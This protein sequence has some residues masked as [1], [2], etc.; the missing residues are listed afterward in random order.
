MKL[1]LLLVNLALVNI[2]AIPTAFAESKNINNEE[3]KPSITITNIPQI[4][5]IELPATSAKLLTQQP[6]TNQNQNCQP[7]SQNRNEDEK[8]QL[9]K[10]K[11]LAQNQEET[12]D[13]EIT[14]TGTKTPRSV[15]DSPG[16]ITVIDTDDID[17]R[18]IQNLDDLIRYEP[19][20]ST[21]GDPR[22]Y[23]FQDFNIRGIDGNRILLQVDGVRLPESFSFGSTRLGRNYV[24]IETLKRAEIIRGSAST[25]Y[26]SDAIGGVVTFITKDPEDYLQESGDDAYFSNKFAYDSS[27][28]GIA[29]TATVAGRSGDVEGLLV[30]TRRDGYEPQ[31]NSSRTPNPQVSSAN[32]WLAKLVFNLSDFQ[33]IKLTGE[34]IN[35]T[36]NTDVLTSRGINLGV[37]TDNLNA[38]DKTKRNRY[39]LSYEYDNPNNSLF[40]QVLRSQIYYQDAITTEESNELRRATAPIATGEVN[41][42]RYRNSS[43]QQNT[44]G[45][46]LQLESNFDTGSLIHKLVY[47]AEVSQTKTSRLRDGFQENI[48]SPGV[49]GLRTNVVGPDAFPVKDIADTENTKFGIYLQDE[50]T[51]GN[52]TLIPGIR[53]D[54]YSLNPQPDQ[55]YRNSSR[56][57]PTSKF[58]DSAISPKLGLVYKLTPELTTFAQYSRGFRAPTAEDINPAFTNPGLYTVIPN[59]DLKPESS[60]N[61]E[62][63]IRGSFPA[64]KFSFSGFYNTYN[65]FIDTF[66]RVIPTSGLAVGTFQTVNRGEVRIYGLEAKGELP[67][68]SGFSLLASTSYAVGDDLQTNQ[69]L[70]SIDPLRLV[71][72]LRYRSP[73]DVW[74]T[75]L[76]TTYASSPRVPRTTDVPNPFVPESY[77]TLDLISYYNLSENATINIGIF[78]ILNEKYWRRGDVRGLSATDPNIDLFTQPGISLTA[79]LTV[80]F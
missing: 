27:N 26:G 72:G 66:G 68:G 14:V 32:S 33:K 44:F 15:D 7:A 31:I 41:R 69:P 63:G 1:Y 67:L 58:S 37:R 78:N 6:E 20:V 35:L 16:T 79:S 61:F 45:G 12:T 17:N 29:E 21:S 70:A 55:I 18:L 19:G 51:W 24:D 52:L 56:N 10:C 23:G 22:R 11:Q 65:N 54:S 46:D 57:F 38:T 76:I 4:S 43:Y 60:N 36:T 49:I 74:G 3:K 28:R 71:A 40:F 42:R 75:E 50:I 53:Y 47:G 34:F 9:D 30:Y 73:Q 39:N 48:A 77:F 2:A 80:R 59:P 62:L 5:E 13:I 64:G 25:L 8:N